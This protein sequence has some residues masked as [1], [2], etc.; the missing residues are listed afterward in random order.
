M[1]Y[2][3]KIMKKWQGLFHLTFIYHLATATFTVFGNLYWRLKGVAGND[4]DDKEDEQEG[5]D[6]IGKNLE[7]QSRHGAVLMQPRMHAGV[8]PRDGAQLLLDMIAGF[9]SGIGGLL[10]IDGG[11]RLHFSGLLY[12]LRLNL[13]GGLLGSRCLFLV[14]WGCQVCP[15][16]G[17][18][19]DA[20]RQLLAAAVAI[21]G[22]VVLGGGV[23]SGGVA[24]R[25]IRVVTR[26]ELAVLIEAH[27]KALG[28]HDLTVVHHQFLKGYC[29]P[30]TA[31]RTL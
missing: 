4:D 13:M 10:S 6:G 22:T 31:L 15:A 23:H 26:L 19:T 14:E 5:D 30:F 2:S 25:R 16:I 11:L 3:A 21:I 17:A 9:L 1:L 7:C 20:R 8:V 27:G 29:H 12:G 18:K 24:V 28:A